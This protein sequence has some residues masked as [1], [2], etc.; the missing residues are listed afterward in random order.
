MFV[1]FITFFSYLKI[2]DHF[3]S[4]I[5]EHYASLIVYPKKFALCILYMPFQRYKEKLNSGK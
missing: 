3:H 1:K 5:Y 4:E 2:H